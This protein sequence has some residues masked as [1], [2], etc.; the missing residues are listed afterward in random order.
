MMG[1]AH[2]LSG[3][4][5]GAVLLP[6]APVD[7]WASQAAWVAS[8]AGFALLPD[9]DTRGA[10]IGRMWGAVTAVL[11]AG[12][13]RVA[14][15]HRSGTHDALVAPVVFAAVAVAAALHPWTQLA[16]LAFALGLA[17]R[18]ITTAVP[19]WIARSVLGN[20]VLSWGGA[21]L[22]LILGGFTAPWLPVA[23][24]GGV[25]V[26][27]AGDLATTGGIPVPLTWI[28]GTT[29]RV[30]LSLFH[31]GFALERLVVT[32]ALTLELVVVLA[33]S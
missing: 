2:A 33:L 8:W 30:S 13:G 28:R 1:H 15:G 5:A 6:V 21:W 14:R 4:L 22:L 31:T 12:I 10:T 32:P 7:S 26:H 25:L 3:A 24:A 16:L 17:L 27:I 23:V 18:A 29:A 19:I 9:L 20:L 11:A